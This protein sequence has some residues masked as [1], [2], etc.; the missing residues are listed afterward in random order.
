LIPGEGATQRLTR[1]VGKGRALD[2]SLTGKIVDGEEAERIGLVTYLTEKDAL[3][4]TINEGTKNIS[5]KGPIAISLAKKAVHKGY[6]IDEDA[7][8]WREKISQEV[9]VGTE[10]KQEGTIAC[11]ENEI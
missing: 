2:M 6:D 3:D 9:V 5:K 10:D 8:Q 1:I 7:A 4:D 11:S